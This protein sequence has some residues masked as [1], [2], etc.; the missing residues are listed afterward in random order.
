MG[1]CGVLVIRQEQMKVLQSYQRDQFEQRAQSYLREALPGPCAG[2]DDAQLREVIRTGVARAAEYD[3]T[4]ERD[5][6]GYLELTLSLGRDFD[7]D[8][9]YP[10]ARPI[11]LDRLSSAENRLRRLR[12]L[13]RRQSR[14]ESAL[15]Q[16]TQ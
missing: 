7:T 13:A 2:M 11:L 16:A 9:A 4:A 8:P 6:I 3:I 12:S 5:V 1:R 15:R 10:W 14:A